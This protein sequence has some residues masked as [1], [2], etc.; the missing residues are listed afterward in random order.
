[1]GGVRMIGYN[2]HMDPIPTV[3]LRFEDRPM[4]ENEARA[5]ELGLPVRV[6]GPPDLEVVS[7]GKDGQTLR[8]RREVRRG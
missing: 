4:T 6:V 8:Q 5:M 3:L 2:R 1:M 7:T